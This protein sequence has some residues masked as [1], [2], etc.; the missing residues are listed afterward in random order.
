MAR[1]FLNFVENTVLDERNLPEKWGPIEGEQGFPLTSNLS[2]LSLNLL[3]G[4]ES[5]SAAG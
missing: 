5:R 4:D 2:P 3:R 1:R